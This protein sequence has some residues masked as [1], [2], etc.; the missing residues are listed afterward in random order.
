MKNRMKIVLRVKLPKLTVPYAQMGGGWYKI[1][2][3][4]R[5]P[6]QT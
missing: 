4:Y 5:T 6:Y 3:G 2:I 1:E